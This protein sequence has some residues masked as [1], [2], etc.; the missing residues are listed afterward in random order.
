MRL[1]F[2]LVLAG[3]AERAIP[4]NNATRPIQVELHVDGWRAEEV[5]DR[6]ERML[7][8]DPEIGLGSRTQVETQVE[9]NLCAVGF[10]IQGEEVSFGY[11]VHGAIRDEDDFDE[12]LRRVLP[13]VA[14]VLASRLHLPRYR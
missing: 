6:L 12:C 3:C 11:W 2:V 14:D 4:A 13:G 5:H 10:H 8:R 1:S 7:V 9:R